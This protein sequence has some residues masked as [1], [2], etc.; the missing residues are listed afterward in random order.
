MKI[1]VSSYTYVINWLEIHAHAKAINVSMMGK[2]NKKW[3]CR[4]L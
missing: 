3:S 4:E 2:K 1:L